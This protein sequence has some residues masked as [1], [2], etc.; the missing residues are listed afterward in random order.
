MVVEIDAL[1]L[2][3]FGDGVSITKVEAESA[4]AQKGMKAGDIIAEVGGGTVADPDDVIN[5]VKA[6]EK[7]GRKAILLRI[8]SGNEPRFVALLI[9]K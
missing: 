5:A 9:R 2:A 1:R 7:V 3:P 6:A 4:A 8:K